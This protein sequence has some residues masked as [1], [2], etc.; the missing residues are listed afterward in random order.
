M[1]VLECD[2]DLWKRDA[3]MRGRE[4]Q[5]VVHIVTT[6][7]QKGV[8]IV[9]VMVWTRECPCVWVNSDR[10]Q[11]GNRWLSIWNVG[12]KFLRKERSIVFHG[13]HKW[14]RRHDALL[15]LTQT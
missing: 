2:F 3:L 14:G 10:W 12:T 7:H 6:V 11:V 13:V 15:P 8:A 1:L 5:V 4:Q 9:V